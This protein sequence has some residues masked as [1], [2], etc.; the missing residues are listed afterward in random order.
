[1]SQEIR[2]FEEALEGSS[3]EGSNSLHGRIAMVTGGA[4]G[5]GRAIAERVQAAGAQ[6]CI[7]DCDPEAGEAVARTLSERHPDRPVRFF[8]ANLEEMDEIDAVVR[9]FASSHGQVDVLV[10]NAGIELD[11]PFEEVTVRDWERIEAVNLRAPFFLTQRM[12]PFFP[13][14]GGAII[15]IGSIHSTHAF[16]NATAYACSKAALVSL[17]RN[18]ALELAPRHIRVNALSPGYIDTRLWEVYLHSSPDPESLAAST[19]ALHPLGRRGLPDDIAQAALFLATNASSFITGTQ[20]V[21]DGGLT[22]RAH[23]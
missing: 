10:N 12:L 4:R 11:K 13:L 20:I 1:M 2:Q 17:T 7:V 6:V 5:I 18:L 21:V 23:V 15:N 3:V 9:H 19:T 8:R 22:I 16:K 14:S